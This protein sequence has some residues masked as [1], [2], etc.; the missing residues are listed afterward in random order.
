MEGQHPAA[1]RLLVNLIHYAGETAR[2][3]LAKL[4]AQ[5]DK[6]WAELKYAPAA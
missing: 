5:F 6:L 1:G 2:G 3:P 4:P